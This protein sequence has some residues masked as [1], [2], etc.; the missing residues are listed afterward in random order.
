MTQEHGESYP[1][2][3]EMLGEG[4][5]AELAHRICKTYEANEERRRRSGGDSGETR[6]AARSRTTDSSPYYCPIVC[7]CRS[8]L[9]Q[10][11]HESAA[12][13]SRA[14]AHDRPEGRLGCRRE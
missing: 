5:L 1:K 2:L 12:W 3:R 9:L 7:T 13:R 6:L 8:R 4:A 11:R 14:D 10:G